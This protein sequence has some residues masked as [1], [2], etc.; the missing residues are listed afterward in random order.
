MSLQT[1]D[2]GRSRDQLWGR[3]D[4][5]PRPGQIKEC[6][7][8]VGRCSLSIGQWL[9]IAGPPHHLVFG[10]GFCF[11]S[12]DRDGTRWD[13][14]DTNF[15]RT[16]HVQHNAPPRSTVPNTAIE[17]AAQRGA[18]LMS[19]CSCTQSVLPPPPPPP[20]SHCNCMSTISSACGPNCRRTHSELFALC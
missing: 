9:L 2:G 3:R 16:M 4:R 12:L 17:L 8:C 10:A 5:Q 18:Q 19:W 14:M 6:R 15:M 13:A 7:N 1:S 11:K 20:P